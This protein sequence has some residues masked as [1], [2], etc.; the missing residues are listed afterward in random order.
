MEARGRL[1]PSLAGGGVNTSPN[2]R[3]F[4][5]WTPDA[6]RPV[7]SYTLGY[8]KKGGKQM[9]V[10]EYDSEHL[11]VPLIHLWIGEAVSASG[12]IR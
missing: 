11:R 7:D 5:F 2:I 8:T 6:Y 4:K 10:V 12:R 9:R 1:A 3:D